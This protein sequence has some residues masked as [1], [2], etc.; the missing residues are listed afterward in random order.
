MVILVIF[1]LVLAINFKDLKKINLQAVKVY[2]Q[3]YGS[4]SVVAFLV[5]AAIRPLGVLIP[6]TILTLIA[7]SLYGPL[8]GFL[9]AMASIILSSNIA[10][11]ISRYLGRS[12]VERLLKHKTEKINLKVEKNGFKIILLM[13]L[14][15]V[16]P[17]DIVSF[18]AG[19]TKVRY[20]DFILATTLGSMPETFSVS[21]MG[22]NIHN[23]LSPG[24]IFSVVLVVLTVGIPMIYNR[25][26][27]KKEKSEE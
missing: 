23:P 24:F 20:W 3:S 2:I 19:L 12:F 15:G 14:S 6:V 25:V 26:K 8:Y 5:I 27:A 4:L 21:F 22:H 1:A 10:F 18:A 11:F 17:L 13:R 9:L 16:F 7:G